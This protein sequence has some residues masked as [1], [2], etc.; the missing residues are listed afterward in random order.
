[1][2]IFVYHNVKKEGCVVGVNINDSVGIDS[3]WIYVFTSRID[4]D[5]HPEEAD[6]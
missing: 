6:N 3:S 1:M 4:N 2:E 5:L